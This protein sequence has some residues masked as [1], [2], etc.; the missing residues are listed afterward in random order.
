MKKYV[1]LKFFFF[2]V[3]RVSV[4]KVPLLLVIL[5]NFIVIVG[6]DTLY[7]LSFIL[8]VGFH[9]ISPQPPFTR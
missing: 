4:K 6:T 1:L 7:I 3:Y 2:D 9:R 8:F 5:T